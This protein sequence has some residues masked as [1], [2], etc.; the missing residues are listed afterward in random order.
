MRRTLSAT[1][2]LA[3]SALAIASAVG[4]QS[5]GGSPLPVVKPGHLTPDGPPRPV[6]RPGSLK[7][8]QPAP[9]PKPRI[10]D[11]P[12]LPVEPS[13][14][15]VTEEEV[16]TASGPAT[17]ATT[18]SAASQDGNEGDVV[19]SV[20]DLPAAEAREP[21]KV[22][23]PREVFV[24]PDT[25]LREDENSPSFGDALNDV[26]QQMSRSRDSVSVAKARMKL[27][28][29]HLRHGH[30]AEAL[31]AVERIEPAYLTR[32]ER[33]NLKAMRG[34]AE[35]MAPVAAVISTPYLLA[36]PEYEGWGDQALWSV[37][38]AI[39]SG[40]TVEDAEALARAF[41]IARDH[42]PQPY[43]VDLYP[44]LLEEALS[45][46]R[47]SLAKRIATELSA[48]PHLQ[49]GSSYDY[50]LGFAAHKA[51]RLLDAFDAYRSASQGSDVYAQRARL[52]LV[53]I[54]LESEVMPP[55]D[56]EEI[57]EANRY[58]WRGDGYE[59]DLLL[60]L[61]DLK[62]GREDKS[63]AM[64]ALGQVFT[65]Y[66]EAPESEAAEAVARKL[67]RDFYKA[68]TSGEI[69]LSAFTEG[70][71]RIEP[72]FHFV[73]G[74][75]NY[76]ARFAQTLLDQG[77]TTGAAQEFGNA[78]EYLQVAKDL[79]LWEI[80]VA[81]VQ[82]L[83]LRRAD[84]EWQG[85]RAALAATTIAPLEEIGD[86]VLD[87]RL[88]ILKA[89]VFSDLD[90]PDE[91]VATAMAER[92]PRY[93]R[94][95]AEAHYAR[96]DYAQAIAHFAE[97]RAEHPQSYEDGDAVSHV[98]A[99]YR[100]QNFESVLAVVEEFPEI[101]QSDAWGEVAAGLD[102][103]PASLLPLNDQ[104]AKARIAQADKA[105]S[106]IRLATERAPEAPAE[107]PSEAE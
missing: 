50:L 18:S 88:N 10:T 38:H 15:V 64:L 68:G 47:W 2:L 60:K 27:A 16:S 35:I 59:I 6:P 19:P 17:E 45:G 93:V 66:P 100:A 8:E 5:S 84:A 85:G 9:K 75:E 26:V 28:L 23:A 98:I 25:F 21:E 7:L 1:L 81:D 78:A 101:M 94:M 96:G 32:S 56:A 106:A 51:D 80:D 29:L 3:A 104:A 89:E 62:L 105:M 90:N 39:R 103:E 33:Q 48:K 54:G 87:D 102:V 72:V 44:L 91:V 67:L 82:D 57:L 76:H 53:E 95:L 41:E 52:G 73:E 69:S 49:K 24:L 13:A 99:A 92:T 36:E 43:K 11:L 14:T 77:L 37:V 20:E 63:G 31:S 30:Y 12:P 34:V 65:R 107:A 71:R 79:G 58:M 40:V 46:S 4:A 83:H 86:P 55:E 61:A 97:L 70:H 74:F 22:V 42:Y